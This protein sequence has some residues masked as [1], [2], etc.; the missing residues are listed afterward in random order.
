MN[1]ITALANGLALSYGLSE[2]ALSLWRRSK[3]DA[4]SKD[5]GSL[6]RIWVTIPV[7]LAFAFWFQHRFPGAMLAPAD[8]LVP[9][10]TVLF[11]LGLALRWYSIFYLG[12]FFTVNVAI[13]ADHRVIDTG[14]YRL[15]RHPSYTGALLAFLGLGLCLG[16]ILSLLAILVPITAVFLH[17]IGVEEEALSNALGQS[18][19]DYMQRTRRLIPLLY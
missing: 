3:G 6:R 15:I 10:G 5:Q 2:V 17:R 16:N 4:N 14:P 11:A 13:A 7:S 1:T 9:L 19:T 8:L 18:Y 12:R